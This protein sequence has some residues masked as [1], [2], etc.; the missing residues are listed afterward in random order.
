MGL[1]PIAIGA[2]DNA[3]LINS[4]VQIADQHSARAD[5]TLS[6]ETPGSQFNLQTASLKAL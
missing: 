1:L 2:L 3:L 5:G 4:C 6:A